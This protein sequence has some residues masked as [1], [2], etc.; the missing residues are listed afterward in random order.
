MLDQAN[1]EFV[2]A[3]VT[4]LRYVVYAW[5][6]AMALAFAFWL[7]VMALRAFGWIWGGI[8]EFFWWVPRLFRSEE[9]KA[10]KRLRDLGY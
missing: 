6:A 9:E 10:K 4:V 5:L 7:I 2:N 8:G 3:A 1:S